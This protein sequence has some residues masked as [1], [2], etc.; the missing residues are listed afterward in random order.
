MSLNRV[1]AATLSA[2]LLLSAVLSIGAA[3]A[4]IIVNFDEGAPKDRFSIENTG[5]CDLG[6]LMLRI[7]LS[8]TAGGLYFDT[9]DAG[10]GVEVFQPLEITSGSEMLTS[11]PEITDGDTDVTLA[12]RGLKRD[13]TLAF[14]IDVDDTLRHSALGQTQ[15]T[16]AEIAGGTV[17]AEIDGA[18][19]LAVFDNTSTARIS[20][21]DCTS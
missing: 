17:I 21:A 13:Q 9:T 1:K 19:T 20:I 18:R 3:S 6:A 16:G 15:V 14:T 12:M 8:E 2:T 10:V 7:D 5:G 4:A 11:T